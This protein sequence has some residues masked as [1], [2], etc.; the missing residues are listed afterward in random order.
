MTAPTAP[1]GAF[2]G[3]VDPGFGTAPLRLAIVC[4]R[5]AASQEV[6]LFR[7]L[8]AMRA[9]GACALAIAGEADIAA[10][11]DVGRDPAAEIARVQPQALILSRY[12]GRAAAEIIAAAR[13]AGARVIAHLDDFL[14]DVPA[15]LGP[16][17][18]RQ[19]MRP[20]RLEALSLGLR[21]ADLIY[22]STPILAARI[23]AAGFD[24]PMLVSDL[25]SCADPAELAPAPIARDGAVTIG[26]QGTGGHK[27]DLAMI[28][29]AV[30][31][32]L[33]A[34]PQARLELFGTIQPPPAFTALGPRFRH[35]KPAAGYGDFLATLKGLGWDIGLAP[36]RD[37]EFNSF[38]T[39]TKWT[40]YTIAGAAVL[41]SDSPAYR[42]VMT[43]GRGV[44]ARSD[45]WTQTLIGLI[46]H[47]GA[48][49]AC[50]A[51]AQAL[52]RDRLTLAAQAQQVLAMLRQAGASV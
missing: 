13:A 21:A 14:L 41:A 25:Q 39:Y 9:A 51:A 33:E 49:A 22:A 15:D 31:A 6:H 52:L 17:K 30:C 44:M 40:E 50:V 7:P 36:L 27:L 46:D 45:E 2:P 1:E 26:Y 5:P 29:D 23:A 18:V 35:I 34:R 3:A 4:D 20:E 12:G 28:E 8:A 19:H 48:R 16:E 47:A 24:R 43:E 42:P 37:T 38:R 11:L 10:A 32:A